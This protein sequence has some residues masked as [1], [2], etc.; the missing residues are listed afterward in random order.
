[1]KL[2]SILSKS[3]LVALF[4]V[5]I[6]PLYVANATTCEEGNVK[7]CI[8]KASQYLNDEP[9]KAEAYYDKALPSLFDPCNTDDGFACLVLGDYNLK[10]VK[11]LP[12]A[13][14]YY[15][16][17]CDL[18][19]GDGCDLLAHMYLD[20]KNIEKA[21]ELSEKG[22]KLAN[23]KACNTLSNIYKNAYSIAKEQALEREKLEQQNSAQNTES[24]DTQKE[25]KA[26]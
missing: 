7:D 25:T 18:K 6:S 4:G 15:E 9:K 24:S 23:D 14:Y 21:R 1:M 17:S 13:K 11:N 16:K 2:K 22:C 8:A 3:M 19:N 12:K 10:I 26:K 20:E 5:V